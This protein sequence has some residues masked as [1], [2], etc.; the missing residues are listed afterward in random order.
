LINLSQTWRGTS[1]VCG[2]QFDLDCDNDGLASAKE[3]EKYDQKSFLFAFWGD[4]SLLK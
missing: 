3:K 1:E 2:F 4:G